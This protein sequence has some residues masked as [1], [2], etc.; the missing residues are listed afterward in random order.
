MNL[1]RGTVF[2]CINAMHLN[3]YKSSV[4]YQPIFWGPAKFDDH[5]LFPICQFADVLMRR[6]LNLILILISVVSMAYIGQIYHHD[7]FSS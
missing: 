3:D 1:I 7:H 4:F 5:N 2:I 6:W